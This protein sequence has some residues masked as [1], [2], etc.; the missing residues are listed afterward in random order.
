[1]PESTSKRPPID[2]DAAL[3]EIERSGATVAGF[4][5]ERGFPLW[6]LYERLRRRRQVR[7]TGEVPAEAEFIPV[8]LSAAPGTSSPFELVLA[9]GRT[10]RIPCAFEEPALQRLVRALESC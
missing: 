8:R 4:A 10:L 7:S 5:R 3:D 2:L 9:C 6:K 1:M